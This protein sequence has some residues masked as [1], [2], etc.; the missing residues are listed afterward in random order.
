MADRVLGEASR[1]ILFGEEFVETE[2]EEAQRRQ[3][4]RWEEMEEVATRGG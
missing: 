1:L 3:W 4:R 2:R